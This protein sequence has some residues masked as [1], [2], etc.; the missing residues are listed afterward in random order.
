MTIPVPSSRFRSMNTIQF[1]EPFV[2]N[3]RSYVHFSVG[4]NLGFAGSTKSLS[5]LAPSVMYVA[6]MADGKPIR[7]CSSSS[8]F[9][10]DPEPTVINGKLFLY[11]YSYGVGLNFGTDQFHVVTGVLP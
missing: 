3:G 2:Y 4:A 8:L 11:Y 9:R 1:L 6:S 5:S 7:A 10:L